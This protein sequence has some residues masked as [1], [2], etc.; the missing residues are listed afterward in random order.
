MNANNVNKRKRNIIVFFAALVAGAAVVTAVQAH[1]GTIS[2]SGFAPKTAQYVLLKNEEIM[3]SGRIGSV[4]AECGG[5]KMSV[6]QTLPLYKVDSLLEHE[7][8]NRGLSVTFASHRPLADAAIL[9][10][11]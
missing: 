5:N 8:P 4:K 2:I 6:S 10:H 1:A 11:P 7:C 3:F 9:K